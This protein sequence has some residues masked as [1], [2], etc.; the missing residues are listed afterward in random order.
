MST[1]NWNTLENNSTVKLKKI[2]TELFD[3]KDLIFLFVKRDIKATYQ[4]TILGP[5]WLVFQPILTSL[6]LVV[7]GQIARIDTPNGISPF[8]FYLLGNSLWI[9]FSDAFNKT[10]T[11]FTA[12]ASVFGKVY[13]PRLT[14]PISVILSNSYKLLFQCVLFFIVYVFGILFQNQTCLINWYVVFLLPSFLALSLLGLSFGLITS[15][16]TTKY[17][18]LTMLVSFGIQLL[19][20]ASPIIYPLSQIK[21]DSFFYKLIELNPITGWIELAKKGFAP[22]SF[23]SWK[24][25]TY[26]I[27][28]LIVSLLI[29]IKIFHKVE[30]RFMDTV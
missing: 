17:R 15:S 1:E 7:L 24:L 13:F 11:T 12:N 23:F 29:G 19:M 2:F 27:I 18:D 9:F 26:D 10:A 3:Y 16:L 14:V 30:K 4:Q 21:H 5:L 25:I 22:S 6:V 8:A 20:Y 28:F